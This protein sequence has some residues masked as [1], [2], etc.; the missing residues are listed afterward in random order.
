MKIKLPII[1]LLQMLPHSVFAI[2]DE[3]CIAIG[4]T[5]KSGECYKE[6]TAKECETVG[7]SL[8]D[9]MCI[10]KISEAACKEIGGKLDP[11]W[12]CIQEPTEAE[13]KAAGGVILKNGH[14]DI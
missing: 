7:G 10:A 4:G 11:K 13:C 3:Q 5:S 14:C 12:G 9:G 2:T 6:P 8:V 1:L